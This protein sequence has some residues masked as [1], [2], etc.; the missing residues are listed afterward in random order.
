M[1]IKSCPTCLQSN[2]CPDGRIYYNRDTRLCDMLIADERCPPPPT[3][4]TTSTTT[5]TQKPPTGE[6][7]DFPCSERGYCDCYDICRAGN[8]GLLKQ[9]LMFYT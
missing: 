8:N 7:C 3:T 1:S 2:E 5:S 6:E 4:T 9:I